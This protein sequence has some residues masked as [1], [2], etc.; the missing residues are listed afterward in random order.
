MW[1]NLCLCL[2]SFLPCQQGDLTL[3]P[4]RL[5]KGI[6]LVYPQQIVLLKEYLRF[7]WKANH[8]QKCIFMDMNN[9]IEML[10]QYVITV[11]LL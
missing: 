1:G 5:K 7:P 2:S 9:Q 11:I 8:L 10:V 3:K 4:L 6:E